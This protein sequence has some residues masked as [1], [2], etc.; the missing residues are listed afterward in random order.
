MNEMPA[1][2]LAATTWLEWIIQPSSWVVILQVAFGLEFK[3]ASS[4]HRQIRFH[5]LS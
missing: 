4:A 1:A 2:C 3:S 5:C